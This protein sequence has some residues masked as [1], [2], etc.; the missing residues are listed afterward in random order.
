[1]TCCCTT[2]TGCVEPRTHTYTVDDASKQGWV[3]IDVIFGNMAPLIE[4][5]KRFDV[6]TFPDGV[7]RN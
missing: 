5:L 4:S 3:D 1:M 2:H 6:V 7:C